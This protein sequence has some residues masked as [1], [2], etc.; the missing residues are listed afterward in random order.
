M[1]TYANDEI[2]PDLKNIWH[3]CFGDDDNYMDMFFGGRYRLGKCLVY[4]KDST[5][6][7]MLIMYNGKIFMPNTK[8]SACYIYGVA[9]H[10]DY[11]KQG[12]STKLLQKAIEIAD[13]NNQTA[14]LAP[15]TPDL[16]NF[17]SKRGFYPSFHIKQFEFKASP[18]KIN[19][20]IL[21]LNSAEY[22][23]MR[24]EYLADTAHFHWGD[25][26]I[27]YAV[28]ENIFCG[29]NSVKIHYNGK[30]YGI[31]YYVSDNTLYVQEC[32]LTDDVL[33]DCLNYVAQTEHCENISVRLLPTSKF[34]QDRTIAMSNDINLK[35]Y[36]NILFD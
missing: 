30:D 34:G 15:A 1:I 11:Q 20:E 28:S 24:N 23:S 19:V 3:K 4:F 36:M 2:I 27:G 17:Y 29:G 31:L 33:T 13:E 14:T 8:K 18:S 9:T 7:G 16:I 35:A 22:Q 26:I 6:A 12:I 5:P 10:P 21:P 32:T 25:N